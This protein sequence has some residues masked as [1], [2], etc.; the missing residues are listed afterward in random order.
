MRQVRVRLQDYI[1]KPTQLYSISSDSSPH[2]TRDHPSARPLIASVAGL[3]E[4]ASLRAFLVGRRVDLILKSERGFR[5][6]GTRILCLM[7]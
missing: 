6:K 5:L 2:A 1:R 4:G 7:M 3:K